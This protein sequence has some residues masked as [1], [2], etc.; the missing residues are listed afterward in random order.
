MNI[1]EAARATRKY[2]VVPPI[3]GNEYWRVIQ[4]SDPTY[5]EVCFN[6]PYDAQAACDRMNLRAV[7]E[8]IREPSETMVN[9]GYYSSLG[10]R[11]TYQTMIDALVAEVR[12]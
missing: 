10:Q 1:D 12:E 11:E 7:L 9:T 2:S 6:S 4:H 8:A 5:T 3:L